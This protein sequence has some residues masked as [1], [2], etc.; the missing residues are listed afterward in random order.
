MYLLLFF[1]CFSSKRMCVH[2]NRWPCLNI[3]YSLL[4]LK[5]IY[6]N[7]T[8]LYN[9]YDLDNL[10]VFKLKRTDDGHCDPV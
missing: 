8:P 6:T 1:L 2:P 7:K 10:S 9:D 4:M 3:G 5:H